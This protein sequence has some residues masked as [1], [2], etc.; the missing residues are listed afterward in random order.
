MTRNQQPAEP[1]SEQTMIELGFEKVI[2]CQ[3]AGG[4]AVWWRIE[5]HT[6][7]ERPTAEIMFS[8]MERRIRDHEKRATQIRIRKELGL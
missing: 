4:T 5:D 6:F 8:Q 3:V 2:P 7:F 1:L